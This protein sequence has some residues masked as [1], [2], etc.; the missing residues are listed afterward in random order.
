MEVLIPYFQN[1][2][3]KVHPH[4]Q[5]N[6][7]WGSI[8]SDVDLIAMK[9]ERLIGIEIKSKK[10]KFN[11][12]FHQINKI[13]DFFDRFYIAS[14]NSM[15]FLEKH[16][17]DKR[18]GM[19]FISG[20][21]VTKREGEPFLRKPD[22]SVLEMLR[23]MCLSRLAKVVDCGNDGTRKELALNIL[24]CLK[25]EHLKS[26]LK[27]IATCERTCENTCPIWIF[28]NRLILPLRDIQRVLEKY[29]PSRAHD[30]PLP[31]IPA[32]SKKEKDD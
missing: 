25:G 2:G 31:L 10:D 20:N 9:D 5:L 27:K 26:V 4:V 16:W 32:E 11:R 28:E 23:K 1:R 12:A 24:P 14:D 21:A 13:H 7:S 18:I 19:L 30:S 17:E 15:E 29:R 8:I 22:L 6:V 3:F